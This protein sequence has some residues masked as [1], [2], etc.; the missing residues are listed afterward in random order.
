MKNLTK[1]QQAINYY[2]QG[3]FKKSFAILRNFNLT[4]N[5]DEIRLF[6]ISHEIFNGH[7]LF[8]KQLGQDTVSIL[9][10]ANILAKKYIDHSL[11]KQ[12]AIN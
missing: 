10:N 4:F 9:K 12:N 3:N 5:N 7:E 8:Y 6:E 2:L 1:K 11:N